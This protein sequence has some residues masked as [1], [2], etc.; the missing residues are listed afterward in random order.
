MRIVF[1]LTSSNRIR[2]KN[3]GGKGNDRERE[4]EREIDVRV[5]LCVVCVRER[6][7][8][9]R[10]REWLWERKGRK[11]ESRPTNFREREC[12]GGK[13]SCGFKHL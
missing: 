8:R 6:K 10:E 1:Y 3:I 13:R 9:E 5:Q 11:G 12:S 2:K 4:R 7:K